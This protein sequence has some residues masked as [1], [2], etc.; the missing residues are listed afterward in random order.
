MKIIVTAGPTR[1]YIDSVR[2]ITTAS[3]GKMGYAAAAEAAAA[4]HDVTLITGP[5]AIEPPAGCE[6][7]HFVTVN[8]LTQALETRFDDCDALI[9]AAAVG[10]FTVGRLGRSG[11]ESQPA[12]TGKISRSAGAVQITLEPTDDILAGL[13][14]RK[15]E[16]QIII[17]FALEDAPVKQAEAK[18]RDEMQ[19]KNA[20]YV[21]LN[22]PAAMAAD[23]SEACIL[24]PTGLV[25]P[26]SRRTKTELAKEIVALLTT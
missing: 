19:R 1:E 16:G 24:S 4:G 10:D 18:A 8:E 6:A 7:V 22:T 21:V 11:A 14:S 13:G 25:L 3:S 2:F 20:D 15:R 5:V 17:A 12:T 23:A 26:W 9:M